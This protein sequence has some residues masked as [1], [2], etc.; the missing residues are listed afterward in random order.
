MLWSGQIQVTPLL[1]KVLQ[2]ESVTICIQPFKGAHGLPVQCKS[3]LSC[4]SVATQ[5]AVTE[6]V[7]SSPSPCCQHTS[8]L[9][10]PLRT[11]SC[12]LAVSHLPPHPSARTWSRSESLAP[13]W[14]LLWPKNR[15]LHNDTSK[16]M[17]FL[18]ET[19]KLQEKRREP[20]MQFNTQFQAH[21][22]SLS[23]N[24]AMVQKVAHNSLKCWLNTSSAQHYFWSQ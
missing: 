18:Q 5:R 8:P 19:V 17:S 11:R 22:L 6:Q 2:V 12:G 16:M 24:L 14:L 21:Y 4:S 20:K 7:E 23:I 10:V 13:V 1:T 3:T 15:H 9:C